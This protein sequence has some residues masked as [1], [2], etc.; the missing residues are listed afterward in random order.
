[1]AS[2]PGRRN[3][4]LLDSKSRSNGA[5]SPSPEE[6]WRGH[7]QRDSDCAGQNFR[8]LSQGARA[9]MRARFQQSGFSRESL[10]ESRLADSRQTKTCGQSFGEQNKLLNYVRGSK[11]LNENGAARFALLLFF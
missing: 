1:Q 11:T 3:A 7:C 10:R 6:S 4:V 2:I 8:A 5:V 9:K